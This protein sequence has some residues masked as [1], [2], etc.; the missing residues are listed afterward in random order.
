[1]V[2]IFQSSIL[3]FQSL[4]YIC[5]VGKLPEILDKKLEERKANNALR[6]LTVFNKEAV[7][8]YSNDYIGF[9]QEKA[10]IERAQKSVQQ[11]QFKNGSSGSRLISGTHQLHLTTEALLADFHKAETALLFNSGYDAN[12]G[13]FS[14]ILQRGTIVLFDELI[15]ASVRD[16]IQ[17][18]NAKSYKFKHNSLEDLENKLKRFAVDGNTLFVAVETV[19]SMD[20]DVC[21][22]DAI[23]DLCE[24]YKAHLVV[25]EAHS[26][27]VFGENGSGLICEKNLEAKVFARVHTFGKALG[28]HGA[29]V[30]GSGQL[31]DY[32]INFSRAFIY[33]TAIPLHAVAIVYEAYQELLKTQSIQK[34]Q[35]NIQFFKQEVGVNNLQ[36]RFIESDS[37]IHCCI[38]SGNHQV[39]QVANLLNEKGFAVKPILS[40][41][42]KQGE[43]RLRICLHSFNSKQ[44]IKSLVEALA[45]AL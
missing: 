45:K 7:D 42:V 27:G 29:V 36:E 39:K 16:G 22:V 15:H 18:S 41:T 8:F 2:E 17:M 3:N 1:M 11:E 25:D 14:S 30:L 28:C 20:G 31:R 9:A 26:N 23:V 21:S 37:A 13:L 6:K 24:K 34:L 19:Y 5:D 38:I 44:E 35:E 12:V 43:E 32:L 40:P 10:I 33:T 4:P